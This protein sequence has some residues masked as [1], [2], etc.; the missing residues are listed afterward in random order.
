MQICQSTVIYFAER[1]KFVSER[2]HIHRE[3]IFD[4]VLILLLNF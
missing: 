1:A 3:N 2:T 4:S